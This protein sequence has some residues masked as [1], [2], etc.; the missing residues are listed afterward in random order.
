MQGRRLAQHPPR[1]DGS[2]G[3]RRAVVRCVADEI[4][5]TATRQHARFDG[6]TAKLSDQLADPSGVKVGVDAFPCSAE[7]CLDEQT[8]EVG[9][10]FQSSLFALLG[11]VAVVPY[12]R[13]RIQS[14]LGGILCEARCAPGATSGGERAANGRR[15]AENGARLAREWPPLS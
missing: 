9:A 12:L 15:C 3:V 7:A 13:Q 8:D 1:H 14:F 6:G 2:P 10:S 4:E 5:S 11:H